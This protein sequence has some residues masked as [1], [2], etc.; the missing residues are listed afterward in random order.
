[1]NIFENCEASSCTAKATKVNFGN[2]S[3]VDNNFFS[4]DA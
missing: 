3:K 4:S 1:M 2:Y